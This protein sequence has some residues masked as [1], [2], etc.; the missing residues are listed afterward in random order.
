MDQMQIAG[1]GISA[2]STFAR[3]MI[4]SVPF[5]VAVSG[6]VTGLSLVVSAALQPHLS[7]HYAAAEALAAGLIAGLVTWAIRRLIGVRPRPGLSATDGP[8]DGAIDIGE[9]GTAHLE[10]NI[11]AGPRLYTGRKVGYLKAF[12]NRV[13][14]PRREE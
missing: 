4:P 7:F 12:R 6:F 10:D 3:W 13:F 2:M 9:V 1:V 11:V 8:R 5:P 14:G